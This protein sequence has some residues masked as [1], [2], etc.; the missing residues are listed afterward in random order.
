MIVEALEE[1]ANI[2]CVYIDLAKAFDKVDHGIMSHKL[3]DMGVTGNLGSWIHGFITGRS[4]QVTVNRSKSQQSKIVSGITQGS[5]LGPVLFLIYVGDIRKEV[6][7]GILLY[8][9]DVKAK[10][11]I[12]S[13]EDVESFQD[14]LNKLYKWGK[15]NNCVFN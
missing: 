3:Q 9:D 5:V 11:V 14:D 2:D 4:Q 8:V 7:H 12:Y 10:Q 1:G 13:E 6:G 15:S